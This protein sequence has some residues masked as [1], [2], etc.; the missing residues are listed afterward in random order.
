MSQKL[1][2]RVGPALLKDARRATCRQDVSLSTFV[3]AALH[4]AL[5][6]SSTARVPS[7]PP[8]DA[9]EQF[10]MTLP[11]EV[12]QAIRRSATATEWPLG[13]VLQALVVAACQPKTMPQSSMSPDKARQNYLHQR[14]IQPT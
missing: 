12:E 13:R 5:G 1:C 2:L 11:R 3:R 14:G 4:Q 10:I 9:W 8:D 7:T 6:Q